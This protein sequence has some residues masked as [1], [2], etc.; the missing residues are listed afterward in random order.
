MNVKKWVAV[1]F[2]GL[3]VGSLLSWIWASDGRW[4]WTALVT[5]VVTIVAGSLGHAQDFVEPESTDGLIKGD[6]GES[7]GK[8]E[9]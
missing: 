7:P 1:V 2:A 6:Q 4:F 8:H 3:T 9:E 5:L